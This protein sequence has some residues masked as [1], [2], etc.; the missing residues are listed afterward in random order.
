MWRQGEPVALGQADE[1]E[2]GDALRKALEL[3][4]NY[5]DTAQSYGAGHS[6][7][8]LGEALE[9]HEGVVVS[10]KF[11]WVF[12]VRARE[13]TGIDISPGAIRSSLE[14]SL[15]RL[16]RDRV[17]L[18]YMH[19]VEVDREDALRARETLEELVEEGK[20]G[21]YG[22]STDQVEQGHL[23]AEGSGCTAI[24]ARFNVFE[25]NAEMLQ[26]C[27]EYDLA[28]V[29]RSPLATGML[30]GAVHAESELGHDDWRS[31]WDLESGEQAWRLGKMREIGQ[32]LTAGGRSLAQ[33]ALAWVWG[34]SERLIPIPGFQAVGEVEEN[35]Q[36]WRQGPL[37]RQERE[38]IE[39]ILADE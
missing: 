24:Q 5:F 37:S 17:E 26:L 30:A 23:F 39:R 12:D 16:R 9:G 20:I 7:K 2:S 15:R 18:L 35:V 4:V 36:A 21:A 31:T 19:V 22:W 6:E 10:T 29:C 8:V 13:I 32:V 27:E 14:Q 34:T 3:G 11:G 28:L 25:R 38:E 33:G 1:G